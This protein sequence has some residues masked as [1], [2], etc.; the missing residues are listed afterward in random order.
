MVDALVVVVN[1]HGQQFLGP[2]LSNDVLIQEGLDFGRLGQFFQ[3]SL[4]TGFLAALDFLQVVLGYLHAVT[5]D[6][7][8]QALQQEGY[9]LLAT[10]AEHAVP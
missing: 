3:P 4:R 6:A 2:V 5:A 7:P 1:R 8:L 9:L 10:A